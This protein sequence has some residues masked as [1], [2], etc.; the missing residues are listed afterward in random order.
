MKENNF[1][2]K[3]LKTAKLVGLGAAISAIPLKEGIAQNKTTNFLNSWKNKKIELAEK[4]ILYVNDK[5]DQRLKEYKDSLELYNKSQEWIKNVE[6]LGFVLDEE[7]PYFK[8][9]YGKW[10]VSYDQ[11]FNEH[12]Y[13][14]G[15][16]T[17]N[18]LVYNFGSFE[19]LPIT[20]P[21]T[22]TSTRVIW[23]QSIGP[24]IM[25]KF[26]TYILD[27]NNNPWTVVFSN[28]SFK[29]MTD[30]Q[31]KALGYD[32]GCGRE[33][34]TK[35]IVPV[36][37]YPKQ[38]V[39]YKFP[40]RHDINLGWL[41]YGKP[42]QTLG[43]YVDESSGEKKVVYITGQDLLNMGS[44]AIDFLKSLEPYHGTNLAEPFKRIVK[45]KYPNYKIE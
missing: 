32:L 14:R 17:S 31:L 1:F 21:I 30:E 11:F 13:D 34:S 42:E 7:E 24:P 36:Y 18:S 22:K 29:N 33:C 35:E 39:E 23:D 37:D 12:K 10:G 16:T 26:N 4:P 25:K 41:E 5:N 44:K 3:V 2:K 9:S 15:D 28:P 43:Y 8:S 27:K 38:K 40:T 45:E 19:E 20:T 6:S